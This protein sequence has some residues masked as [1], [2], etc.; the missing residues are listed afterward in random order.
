MSTYFIQGL[1]FI[2]V[3]SAIFATLEENGDELLDLIT[4][5][6]EKYM[7]KRRSPCGFTVRCV[8]RRRMGDWKKKAKRVRRH[9]LQVI[10]GVV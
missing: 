6:K 8:R 5:E 3:V 2:L 4:E 7:E 9:Y 10:G 1:I